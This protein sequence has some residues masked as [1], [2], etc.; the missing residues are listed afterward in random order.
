MNRAATLNV[1]PPPQPLQRF[2]GA[3]A[4]ATLTPE[5]QA[6]IGAIALEY[7]VA[8]IGF[9]DVNDLDFLALIARPL[10]AAEQFLNDDLLVTVQDAL[11]D[12]VPALTDGTGLVPVPAR[13]GQICRTCGCSHYDPCLG[14]CSWAEP[15]LCSACVT[16]VAPASAHRPEQ[17]ASS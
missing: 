10:G 13:L 11:G 17:G 8:A 1:I 5:Q 14:G 4:W 2:D 9:D 6:E 12:T 15:D 16:A 3:A 7:A